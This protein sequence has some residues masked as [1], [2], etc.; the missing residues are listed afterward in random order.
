M[1]GGSAAD[2]FIIR[3]GD[4]SGITSTNI[5]TP[6]ALAANE[7]FT[8]AAIDKITGFAAGDKIQFQKADGTALTFATTVLTTA[9]TIAGATGSV[10]M[11]RGTQTNATTFTTAAGADTIVFFDIDGTGAN[12]V[13]QAVILVGYTG[14]ANDTIT[15]GGLLTAV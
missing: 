10:V 4:S 9:G 6:G 8:H 12:A 14:L 13:Y 15:A 7:A 11:A 2:T 5:A 1:N 3:I